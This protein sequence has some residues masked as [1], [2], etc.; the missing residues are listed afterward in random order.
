M[1]KLTLGQKAD[2]VLKLLL[3]M[4]NTRVVSALATRGFG[5]DD[6]DE[7]WRLLRNVARG[8]FDFL[9]TSAAD[10]TVILEI[11]RWENTWFPV[12]EAT[13]RRRYPGV[14]DRIFLNLSQTEG[15]GVILS[16]GTLLERLD[17]LGK[18]LDEES[19]AAMAILVRRGVTEQVL[20]QARSLLNTVGHTEPSAPVDLEGQREEFERAETEL[21]DWYLEWSQIA[22]STISDRKLLRSLGF[23]ASSRPSSGSDDAE[24]DEPPATPTANSASAITPAL[25]SQVSAKAS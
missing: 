15:A 14:A 5:T 19:Q 6:I 18:A 11:D 20:G 10:P 23:L 22:R 1:S 2:R 13:L 21:W 8:K 12:I 25:S 4:R 3:G 17:V 7:G 16:V 24:D 9:S